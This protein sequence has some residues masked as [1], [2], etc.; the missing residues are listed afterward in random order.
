MHIKFLKR[1]TGSAANAADY[2]IGETDS[3]GNTRP[4]V[5][6]LRG[7]PSRVAEV[8]D[9]LDF[10]HKYTSCVIA[11][12]P[13]D[14]P[15]DEQ[16][17]EVLNDFEETAFSGLEEDRYCWSAIL[18][19]EQNGGVHVHV[20]NARVELE[21]G[22]SLI[23]EDVS[24]DSR[25]SSRVDKHTR[26]ETRSIIGIPLKTD[27][28]IFGVIELVN[29]ITQDPFT[30][31]DLDLLSAIGEFAAI[32]LE[33]A[34]YN[35]ALTNLATKDPLTG[36]KN[37]WSFERTVS[38]KNEFQ[39]RFGNVFSILLVQMDGLDRLKNKEGD[40]ACEQA[41]VSLADLMKETKRRDD[42]LFR[43]G[44][45]SFI[46][47][48]PLTYSDGAEQVKQRVEKA[49]SKG[50]EKKGL[51]LWSMAITA[52][53][54][55]GEDASQLKGLVAQAL[56]RSNP[57]RGDEEIAD[58]QDTLQPLLEKEQ[59]K[60]EKKQAPAEADDTRKFGKTVS[61]SGNFKRLKTGEFGRIRVEQV[62]LSAIGF[63][64]SKS[65]RIRTNDFLD[66]QFTLDDIKR[67]LIKRRTVVREI[68]GNYIY[69]D[70]YNPPPYAKN[71]GFYML[72]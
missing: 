41:L 61:L 29:R 72:N 20:F 43:Y 38:N 40:Q 58:I 1:G 44:D 26:F 68:Q 64:I 8:A 60:Q 57:L 32:A 15:T 19:R 50:L 47:L 63:R 54:M 48:L 37:R 53:T 25:F 45:N 21:T 22:K 33:R 51:S 28:K 34:Y 46:A 12:A 13:E 62:S 65:H 6:V 42:V 52:H 7:D 55:A 71:L 16:I 66:I 5:S 2:L 4:E 30:Q 31:K 27:G 59:A 39:V 11:W 17:D 69:A 23:I 49:V 18:H 56:S 10:K 35:Q 67:S 9:S 3:E 24:K 14:R 70:F 36:L